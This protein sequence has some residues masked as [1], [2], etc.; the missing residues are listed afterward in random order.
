MKLRYSGLTMS[1]DHTDQD[2]KKGLSKKIGVPIDNILTLEVFRRSIDA[3]KSPV[4]FSYTVDF[5]VVGDVTKLMAAKNIPAAS[6]YEFAPVMDVAFE[7]RP[8]VVGFG[9]AGI[10]AAYYLAMAGLN[11][12]VLERGESVAQRQ[13]S[14]DLFW[15]KGILNP[16]SN[17]QFGEGGAGAF[18]DGKLTTRIK[19]PLARYVFEVLVKHGAPEA[20][21]MDQ[22]PHVGTDL[23][24]DVVV[25]M[26]KQIEAWGGEIRF[27]TKMTGL[28]IENEAIVGV[29]TEQAASAGVETEKDFVKTGHVLLAIGHSARD[30]YQMLFEKG[31]AMAAKP[32]AMGLRIE[33]PRTMIDQC[34][35]GKDAG[36][37]L[38]GAADYAVKANCEGRSVY[39]F[40]MCPGGHVINASSVE[41]HL[42]VNGM[43]YHARDAENSNSAL[44]V[45]ISPEDFGD[46]HVLAGL[47]MQAALEKAA[48]DS[49][50]ACS[51]QTAPYSAPVQLVGDFLAD[52][53]TTALGSVT[54]SVTP[55]YHFVNF[56]TLLPNF[57]TSALRLALPQMGRQLQGF[58]RTD[59]VLTGIETRSSSPVRLIRQEDFASVNVKGLYPIGEGA[60][61]A[62]GITS[63]AVDGIASVHEMLKKTLDTKEL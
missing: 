34:Q 63:A 3:R 45:S 36:H 16:E 4:V 51:G 42:V 15:D 13:K 11:P 22:K 7:H 6:T 2:L 60:G 19:D 30:S 46:S 52:Q 5:T 14:V 62:G 18:S 31:V 20:I 53:T 56:G 50:A 47:K 38:L 58:D 21:L 17:V 27:N 43:S 49:A 8:V 26:R 59:A 24:V 33:H 23:L 54:P 1:L 9:P 41:G 28:V 25:S 12:I 40:C 57:M 32:F 37:P 61:Y 10:F 35:Y 48:Y 55:G 29:E 39:S 44:L